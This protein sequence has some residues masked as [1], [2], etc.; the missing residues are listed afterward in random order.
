MKGVNIA[1]FDF[2]V[3]IMGRA[4][5]KNVNPP[6]AELGFSDGAAQMQHFAKDDGLTLFRLPVS[7]QFLINSNTIT[8]GA[9]NSSQARNASGTLDTVNANKYDLLVQACLVTGA[10]C[11]IDIHNYARFEGKIIGQGGPSDAEFANLWSQIASK[12]ANEK[13]VIFGL[14]NEPHDIPDMKLWAVSIQAAVTAIRAAGATTQMILL[15]GDDFTSAQTFVSNGSAGNLSTVHNPDGSNTSLIFD[16]HKYLD[17]DGSGQHLECVSN[18]IEDTFQPLA[19]FL[20]ANKRQA[21]LSETGG[22]NSPS[23]LTNVCN[24]LMFINA[25]PDPYLGYAG[26]SAGGFNTQYNLTETPFGSAGNFTDQS[27]VKQCIVGMRTGNGI[28][29]RKRHVRTRRARGV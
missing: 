15:P 2:G 14:M 6:L 1:G 20:T 28:A 26:W 8:S 5:L 13:K 19:T 22:G 18:H 9:G 16:V 17:V 24:M 29:S 23:C 3:D 4:I 11:A 10:F 27:I 12:Y 21:I 7:W 25:N